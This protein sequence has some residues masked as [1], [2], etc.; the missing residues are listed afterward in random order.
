MTFKG[1]G[2]ERWEKIE[3]FTYKCKTHD[4]IFDIEFDSCYQCWDE[5]GDQFYKKKDEENLKCQK[6]N[7]I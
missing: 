1:M 4:I 5:F 2:E 6:L 7:G 3:G